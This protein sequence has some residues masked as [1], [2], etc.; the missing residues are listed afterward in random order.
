MNVHIVGLRT[1]AMPQGLLLLTRMLPACSVVGCWLL[2]VDC[3]LLVVCCCLL[4][5]VWFVVC[6]LLRVGVV[7]VVVV[8]VV[9]AAVAAAAVAGAVAVAAAAGGGGGVGV[10]VVVVLLWCCCCCCF[11]VVTL[12]L[13]TQS[14][15]GHKS[16]NRWCLRLSEQE[17]PILTWKCASRHH[18]M[19]IFNI[20][21]S[22]SAPNPVSV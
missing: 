12:Q 22:K 5:V 10:V 19:H 3:W 1:P 11:V 16:S 18:A 6:C 21:T 15:S 13:F 2:V 17:T 7:V 20:S 4:F 8:V 14:G 9:A